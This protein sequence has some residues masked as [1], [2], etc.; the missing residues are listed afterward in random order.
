MDRESPE[1]TRRE[2]AVKREAHYV[3]EE[4]LV[5]VEQVAA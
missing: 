4:I 3:L 1:S 2:R 5:G